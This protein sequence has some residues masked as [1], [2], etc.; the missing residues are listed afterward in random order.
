[1]G[2]VKRV[3]EVNTSEQE[4]GLLKT[5]PVKIALK[6]NNQP[7]AV[8]TAR[9]VPIPLLGAVKEELEKMEANDI[10][11]AV[12]DP[13]E[14][15]APMVPVQKK[16]GKT[17]ICVDLKKLNKA[18]KRERFILPTSEGMIAQLRGST[19]FSSLDAVSRFWQIPLDKDSQRLTTFITPYGRY[20]FKHLPFGISSA[21]EIF[22]RKMVETLEGLDGVAV[23][24]DDIIIHGSNTSEHDERLQKV[25]D[26]LESA[27]LK[28]NNEKCVLRKE[29]LHFL[30]QVINK[31]GVRPDPAKVSAVSKLEPPENVQE[32]KR[33]LGMINYLGKYIP[34]LAT[35]G[36]PLYALLKADSVWMWGPAQQAAFEQV[37]EL[38]TTSPTLVYY[39]VSRSTVVS[40]DAS[41]YGIGGVLLQLHGEDWRPVAYCSRRLSDAETRY[42]QIEKECLASVWACERFQMYLYGL[43]AFKLITDHKPL[44]PLMNSRDLDNVPLRCQRLLMR[45][46]RFN[47]EAEYAPGKTLVVADTLSRSPQ[48][49]KELS[50]DTD[51][52]CYVA[53]VMSSIPASPKKIDS[54]RAETAADEQ[55][56][57]VI[58]YIQ[59]GWPEHRAHINTCV[60]EYFPVRNELSMH[61]G[62]VTRG[63]RIVI[64]GRLRSEILERI[65]EGHQGLN[66]CRDRAN[67]SVW[68]P[69]IA[70]QITHKVENCM[71]CREQR[72]AQNREPLLSTPLPD[73]PWK[74]IGIDL[75]EHERESY[76]VIA[77]YYSRY[78][79]I[80]HMPTT[81]SAH[82]I[83]KLRAT[84]ARH[85]IPEEVVSDN[86]PQFN[87]DVFR[88]FACDMDFTHTTS[89]PHN[90]QGNGYAERAVQ[91]AK[92][93]LRQK[94]PLLALMVYRSSPHSSTGVSPAELLMGRKIST[95]LP[96]LA[97]N[98]Q[99]KWPS[100]HHIRARDAAEKSKQAFYYNKRHGVRELTPLQR[101]DHVLTRLDNQKTWSTPEVVAGESVTQRSYLIETEQ[102]ALYRRNRRHLQAVPVAGPP[103]NDDTNPRNNSPDIQ[104]SPEHGSPGPTRNTD[105]LIQTRSV[106][107]VKPV[108]RLD[109]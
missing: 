83:L 105:G 3:G 22:Q 25:L 33:A 64:P 77:D 66:K 100:R 73:R 75:C 18:V 55:L 7:Y 84:F 6:D 74:R 31:D 59:E 89:S 8:C 19:V 79:E 88:G 45:L 96:T 20:C 13:T 26:R 91:T 48:E 38:L 10:I 27:G 41:S 29:E 30:G 28:L 94:D 78:L 72:R 98:L 92:G 23:Y 53:A 82:V 95:T 102:G 93:I 32:L 97:K 103:A 40:A 104:M 108:Q 9:R 16:S 42:A 46:M 5:Q 62:V 101:G 57:E 90:P 34:D 49:D 58:R 51:V 107:P 54:I 11:E 17:R 2:L 71:Y 70:T 76:L 67:T 1:M 14:W 21:P 39:D 68:W 86:G 52:E 56:Q 63:S 85:G 87:S 37:K 80:L 109:L 81:T 43:L 24:M 69:G 65:H 12:T 99:P 50:R 36:Q 15:C 4:F 106:R 60:R 44:I 47:P 61:D 35:V